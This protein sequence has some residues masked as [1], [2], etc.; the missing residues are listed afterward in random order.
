ML[1]ISV[2]SKKSPRRNKPT[3]D[4]AGVRLKDITLRD[5]EIQGQKDRPTNMS[6]IPFF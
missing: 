4:Y 1:L 6:I 2:K 5:D 3:K